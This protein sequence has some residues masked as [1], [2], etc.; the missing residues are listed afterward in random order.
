MMGG[1]YQRAS[2]FPALLLFAK[3]SRRLHFDWQLRT[4][5]L[6]LGAATRVMGVLNLTPDSFSDGGRLASVEQAVEAA[7]GMFAAGAS[8]VDI[9]GESTRPDATPTL[10]VQQEIDRVVPAIEAIRRALPEALLSIDTYH[11]ATAA[12]AVAAGA[13]IVNDVSG[14]LWDQAMA[15][16]CAELACGVVLMHSRGRPAEWKQLPPLAAGAVLPLVRDGLTERLQAAQAAGIAPERIVL[17]PGFGFGKAFEE[18]YPLLRELRALTTLGH[19]LCVGLS[20]KGFLGRTLSP[21]LGAD[22][23]AA[24]RENATLAANTIAVLHGA[25]IVRVHNVRPAVE[26]VMIADAA[27]QG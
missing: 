10:S 21:L 15:A 9:G 7:L 25:S 2:L 8:L 17:D 24:A 14:L 22:A 27:L 4:R 26:A 6:T 16:T 3:M 19:P 23:P 11:A 18:N 12:A 20:R 1:V 5:T 13:E